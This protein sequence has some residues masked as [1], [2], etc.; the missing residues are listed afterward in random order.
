[1]ME[2]MK[3]EDKKDLQAPD[4][5]VQ[6][7]FPQ[8][9]SSL[10]YFDVFAGVNNAMDTKYASYIELNAASDNPGALPKF[11]NPTPRRNYYTG[12]STKYILK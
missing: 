10:P 6:K 3:A 1:M 4:R 7:P 9:H 2:K 12:L 11:C 5:K 8:N